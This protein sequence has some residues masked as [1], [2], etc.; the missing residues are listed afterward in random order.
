MLLFLTNDDGIDGEG[1]HVLAER[2]SKE[3]EVWVIAPDKN[4]SGVS[5]CISIGHSLTLTK[6]KDNIFKYEGTPADCTMVATKSPGLVLPRMPDAVISGINRG[7]NLGTDVVYS[8][9]AAAARQA[10]LNGVPGIA[11]SVESTDNAFYYERLADFAA[12]NLEKLMSMCVIAPKGKMPEAN[13]IFVNVNGLST[14]EPYAGAKMADISFREYGDQMKVTT[15]DEQTKKCSAF[16]SDS[17]CSTGRSYHD[18]EAVYSG[19]VSVSR[20]FAEPQTAPIVDDI[21]FSL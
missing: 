15:I 10:V 20:V 3:H 2:L 9:T 6:I 5:S 21:R 17:T 14:K 18:Y 12:K 7:A 16:P 8:G 11:L 13:T 4:R 19:F 1:L